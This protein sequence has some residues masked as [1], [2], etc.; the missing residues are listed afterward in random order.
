MM[1]ELQITFLYCQ[2]DDNCAKDPFGY[3]LHRIPTNLLSRWSTFNH[4]SRTNFHTSDMIKRCT[5]HCIILWHHTAA[6]FRSFN[7]RACSYHCNTF[8]EDPLLC[9]GFAVNFYG[10]DILAHLQWN[11]S[12]TKH[13]SIIKIVVLYVAWV[14]NLI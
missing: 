13:N 10:S 12:S 1:P 9:H 7:K 3:T 11:N 5:F 2:N 4:P 6:N 14:Q 8:I